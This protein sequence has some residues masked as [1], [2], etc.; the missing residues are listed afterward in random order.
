MKQY[1]QSILI[2]LILFSF[3]ISSALSRI[4]PVF[5]TGFDQNTFQQTGWT[6]I[7]AGSGEFTLAPVTVAAIPSSPEDPSLTNGRGILISAQS[8][9]GSL[10]L[11]PVVN[12]NGQPAL[13]SVSILATSPDALVAVGGLDVAPDGSLADTDGSA[14]Y[15]LESNSRA[16][17]DGYRRVRVLYEPK[18][19]AFIPLF[20]IAVDPGNEGGFTTAMIDNFEVHLL[21]RDVVTNPDLQVL[22]GLTQA[23]PPA[24]TPT[25]TIT[26]IPTQTPTVTPTPTQPPQASQLSRITDFN[27]TNLSDSFESFS[28]AVAHVADDEYAV[29][30]VDQSFGFNDISLWNI[31]TEPREVRGSFLVNETFEDTSA[32]DPDISIDS[33]RVRHIV[34]SDDRSIEKLTSIFLAQYN[35]MGARIGGADFEV[36]R[37]FVDTNAKNPE[38]DTPVDD[39]ILVTWVDDRNFVDDI[40]ARRLRWTGNGV[41]TLNEEDF[42]VNIPFENTVAQ[43]P[44][45]VGDENGNVIAVWSDNRLILG[46]D[47]RNDI[48]ARVFRLD[49]PLTADGTLP[50][51]AAEV[52]VS[53]LDD[54]PDDSFDPRIAY[55]ADS[56]LFMI[57]WEN[58]F[59][60]RNVGRV[61]AAVIDSSGN[62][63]QNEFVISPSNEGEFVRFPDVSAMSEGRFIVTWQIENDSTVY[64]RVYNAETHRFQSSI[65][66]IPPALPS[67]ISAGLGTWQRVA[68]GSNNAFLSVFDYVRG[69]FADVSGFAGRLQ[70]LNEPGI[71]PADD[72]NLKTGSQS[73]TGVNIQSEPV[74]QRPEQKS[75]R[76]ESAYSFRRQR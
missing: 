29:V 48:Y 25:P 3:G 75:E 73:S 60:E 51:S 64:G 35:N 46:D 30:A 41:D 58:F 42:Q 34:W 62:I 1:I 72:F 40:F 47:K 56:G 13:I 55:E 22:F 44:D 43:A 15:S 59:S 69:G 63:I 23:S 52:Q 16:F 68:F 17:M 9:Q 26:P 20:Q 24:N 5:R 38:V 2:V 39:E 8:G 18:S 21:S 7:P 49:T 6:A 50:E 45:I 70:N 57:V 37:L 76:K 67:G 14:A 54:T 32:G 12:T 33:D 74:R 71:P 4:E 53:A 36:N 27:L 10:V 65:L 31:G 19:D 11:G 28:P 61:Q 66:T